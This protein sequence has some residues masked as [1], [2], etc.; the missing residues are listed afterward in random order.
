VCTATYLPSLPYRAAGSCL[1]Q[2]MP[3]S[4]TS[5]SFLPFLN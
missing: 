3:V 4:S 5:Y 1:T 2:V